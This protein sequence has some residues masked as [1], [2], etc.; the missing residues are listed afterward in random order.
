MLKYLTPKDIEDI[1]ELSEARSNSGNGRQTIDLS[2][3]ESIRNNLKEFGPKN[4]A[5]I[6]RINCLSKEAIFEL[7]ALMR[8]GQGE[9]KTFEE[10]ILTARNEFHPSDI[11]YIA[12]KVQLSSYLKNGLSMIGA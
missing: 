2:S 4:N 7:M 8:L 9:E 5:L 3:V 12:A 1:C 11:E 6:D 10:L